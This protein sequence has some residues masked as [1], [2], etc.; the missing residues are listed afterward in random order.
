[1]AGE[2][3]TISKEEACEF[4]ELDDRRL[5]QIAEKGY[6]PPPVK[7]RYLEEQFKRGMYRFA[8]DLAHKKND[9][10]KA[11]EERLTAAKADIA[12]DERDRGREL[13]VLKADIG[14]ALKNISSNQRATL[15]RKLEG[16]LAPKLA[17]LKT[18][19]II[20]RVRAAV[21]EICKIFQDGA[22]KW[23]E[24]YPDGTPGKGGKHKSGK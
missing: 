1:M 7:G 8:R 3:R 24:S 17:G 2:A 11:H 18:P 19:E 15:Q 21:D 9:A 5:R 20:V 6:F 4:A 13:Y 16:E 22:R 23:M 14:P 10:L 12:E